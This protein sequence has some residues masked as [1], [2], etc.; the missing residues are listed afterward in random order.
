MSARTKGLRPAKGR[1]KFEFRFTGLAPQGFALLSRRGSKRWVSTV[2]SQL[3]LKLK[4]F[5][6]RLPTRSSPDQTF[7]S[8]TKKSSHSTAFSFW[9]GKRDSNP[10]QLPW[11]GSALPTELLPQ[12]FENKLFLSQPIPEII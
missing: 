1:T 8:K 9:S 7:I 6:L 12:T 10:R 4:L 2:W 5:K 3:Y 11:Q